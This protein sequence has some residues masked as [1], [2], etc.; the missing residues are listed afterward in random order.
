MWVFKVQIQLWWLLTL[1]IYDRKKIAKGA[2]KKKKKREMTSNIK[3]IGAAAVLEV[4]T[5]K[6]GTK[7]RNSSL[8]FMLLILMV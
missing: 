7:L 8:A 4:Q 5:V 2:K 1:F 6:Q 3:F